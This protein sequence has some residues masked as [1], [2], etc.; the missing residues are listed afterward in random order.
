MKIIRPVPVNQTGSFTRSSTGTYFDKNGVLQTAIANALR[1]SYDLSDLTKAPYA[2]VESPATNLVTYSGNLANAAWFGTGTSIIAT[3]NYGV[4]PD[5]TTTTTHLQFSGASGIWQQT[6]SLS[7][8]TVCTGSV[9]VKGNAGETITVS[10]GGVDQVF[11]L[12]GNWQRL[13]VSGKTAIT[14]NFS[15]STLN[16]ATARDIQVWGAQLETGSVPTS[17]IPTAG[18]TATRAADVVTGTGLIYSNVVESDYPVW[19]A[20]TLYKSGDFIMDL[21]S[22]KIYQSL[23]GTAGAV[24]FTGSGTCVVTMKDL[25]GVAYVPAAGT[26]ITFTPAAG[27]TMPTGLVA[28]TVY[29]ALAPTVSTF[30]VAATVGGA[31][32]ATTSAGSGTINSVAS[33]NYNQVVPNTKYWLDC[34]MDN[35]WDMFDN[36]ITSQTTNASEV[37]VAIIPGAQRVDSV[38]GMN[39]AASKASVAFT[40]LTTGNVTYSANVTLVS[41]SGIQNWYDYMYKP[42]VQL[43]EFVVSGIPLGLST[44]SIVLVRLAISSGNAKCGGL[45]LGLGED[46]GLTEWG[47]K[48]GTIDYSLKTQD[49]FGNYQITPRVFSKRGDFTVQVPTSSVDYLQNLLAQYRA[50]PI[51][52]IGSNSSSG[53][54]QFNAAL[55]Y[56]FYKDFEIN[57]AYNGY[58]ACSL[59]LEGLT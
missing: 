59:T 11:S 22:H 9:F 23:T 45:V 18:T 16:G 34:G 38:V 51:V 55:I 12:N 40:D 50:T 44:S 20:T 52:Y 10:A 7:V 32:L 30:N 13:A 21:P 58:S 5:G 56:G 4:A 54:T 28:G 33:G 49:A 43:P 1:I 48:V 36:S 39:C 25:T 31:A 37:I 46:I 15:I 41:N 8:G 3:A 53:S 35:R 47:A 6:T 14:S 24:T 26:P 17:Y 42:I 27:A 57:I 19:S 29:Y 2:M